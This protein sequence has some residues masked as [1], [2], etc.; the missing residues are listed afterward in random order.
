MDEPHLHRSQCS[1]TVLRKDQFT[2]AR[3]VNP[4]RVFGQTV[5]FGTVDECD[6]VCILLNCTRLSQVR[7]DRAFVTA[8]CLY[9]P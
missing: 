5:I 1:M 9:H 7:Q 8:P 2:Q 6:H 3:R 4:V